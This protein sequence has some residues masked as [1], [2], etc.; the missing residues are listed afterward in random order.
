M[1]LPPNAARSLSHD[2]YFLTHPGSFGGRAGQAFVLSDPSHTDGGAQALLDQIVE[3]LL[4][5]G[6][7]G[8]S[9]PFRLLKEMPEMQPKEEP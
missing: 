8:D 9:E 7:R 1:Q 5:F 2:L 3:T 4:M 6:I